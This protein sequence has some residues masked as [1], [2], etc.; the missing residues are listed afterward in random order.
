[1]AKLLRQPQHKLDQI[2][3]R[4]QLHQ[5][6]LQYFLFY[7]IVLTFIIYINQRLI[8]L[9]NFYLMILKYYY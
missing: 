6:R 4:V 3:I 5:S 9:S 1:M 8:N 7:N 2:N